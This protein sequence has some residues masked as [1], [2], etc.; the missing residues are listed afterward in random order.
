VNSLNFAKSEL[1]AAIARGVRQCVVIGSR[2]LLGDPALQVFAVAEDPVS[3][4]A[5]TLIPTRFASE[6]LAAALETS[7][8]DRLKASLFVWLGGE[9]YRTADAV[10]NT[11]AFIASL[12]KGSGV[13]FDYAAERASPGSL[14][15]SALDALASRIRMAGGSVKCFIQPPAVAAMLRSVGFHQIVDM[16]LDHPPVSGGHLVSAVV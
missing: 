14:T 7:R 2:P 6:T 16:P 3:D 8:F 9:A 10:I 1:A 11:L 13:V 15:H 12:P 5:A 4:S